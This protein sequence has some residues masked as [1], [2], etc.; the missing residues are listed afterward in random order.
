MDFTLKDTTTF[1]WNTTIHKTTQLVQKKWWAYQI[2]VI[3]FLF[4]FALLLSLRFYNNKSYTYSSQQ[5][6]NHIFVINLYFKHQLKRI[7]L[8]FQ[9]LSLSCPLKGRGTR[10]FLDFPEIGALTV[11]PKQDQ[12]YDFLKTCLNNEVANRPPARKR[13]GF[14]KVGT[15]RRAENSAAKYQEVGCATGRIWVEYDSDDFSEIQGSLAKVNTRKG[16]SVKLFPSFSLF[17]S[18]RRVMMNVIRV[19]SLISIFTL[20]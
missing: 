8:W 12:S 9:V 11:D 4:F 19:W 14:G 17:Q 20:L 6:T 15:G 10:L 7:W 2:F 5:L 1:D 13:K 16:D 3:L 18:I